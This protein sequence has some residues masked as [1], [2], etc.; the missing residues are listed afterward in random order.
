M[1]HTR[2]SF[3]QA[4]ALS[5][6]ALAMG[7]AA[8]LAKAAG[9][10]AGRR[11]P[12]SILIL[13]GTG[14]V[15]PACME[16]ALAKGHKVTLF[17]RGRMETLRK[18]GGRPSVVPDG[19][20]VLY[21]NRDPNKTADDWKD[22]PRM[23]PPGQPREKN[24]DSPKGLTQLEGKKWDAVIDTSAFFPR[25]AKASAELLSPNVGQYLFISTISVYKSNARAGAD[26]SAE[27]ATLADPTT[28]DFGAQFE[29][30]G[31]GKVLCEQ[32]VEQACPGKTTLVRPGFIVGPRD[33][34]RRY[35]FWPTR[36]SKGG[37][38]VVPGDPS[39]PIQLIDVRDLAE[40]CIHLIENK[41][42]GAFNATGPDKEL[43]MKAFCEGTRDG[44]GASTTFTWIP[45]DFLATQGVPTEALFAAYPLYI[46]PTG[47]TAGFHRVSV[48]K[49]V[50]HGLKFR[51]C[52]DT[53][54]A[55]LDWLN[56]VSEDMRKRLVPPGPGE[57]GSMALS[58][59]REQEIIKAW[60]EKK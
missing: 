44:V 39:D 21:G 14:F 23:A 22:D 5:A 29:N 17:N 10:P 52:S 46:P 4:S 58:P 47:E 54:K 7:G 30:Y 43:T 56:S 59:E 57:P 60:R 24:A 13:G 12:L 2:R 31:G 20:E 45:A 37:D 19:V 41:T 27:L 32:A 26:E 15:G 42:M 48:A 50:K 9:T 16:A 6:G 55:T 34:T 53:A 36:I 40:F 1:H 28:E 33:N 38:M 25:M 3:L 35:T 18:E 49:A 8:A 11:A 51:P